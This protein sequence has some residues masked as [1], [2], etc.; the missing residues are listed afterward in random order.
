MLDAVEILLISRAQRMTRA[1]PA[2]TSPYT[3]TTSSYAISSYAMVHLSS[4]STPHLGPSPC[5]GA[6]CL[7]QGDQAA[8]LGR[9]RIAEALITA[10]G[11]ALLCSADARGRT[12][13]HA[14]C[15]RGTPETVALLAA[16]GGAAL[17][18]QDDGDGATCLHVAAARGDWARR[19]C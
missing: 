3:A 18:G 7:H 13:L 1:C 2:S 15:A 17:L 10:G 14:A 8:A 5:R 9:A 4:C 19:R 11:D 12:C 6:T 16:A